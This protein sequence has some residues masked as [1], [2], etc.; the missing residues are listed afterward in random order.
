MLNAA[1][2]C[3]PPRAGSSITCL[4]L[5][6]TATI[7]T[8]RCY[9]YVKDLTE[10]FKKNGAFMT[11]S[12]IIGRLLSSLWAIPLL[13]GCFI[14]LERS[15]AAREQEK[16]KL[17]EQLSLLQQEKEAALLLQKALLQQLNSESDP[18]WVELVL[19]QKLGLVPEG[20]TK[21]FFKSQEGSF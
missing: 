20:K 9:E 2:D 6:I 16:E 5:P 19:M 8:L 13:L 1:V 10:L 12:K 15:L 14:I 7:L 18:A 21:V 17:A 4:G 11:P 3:T